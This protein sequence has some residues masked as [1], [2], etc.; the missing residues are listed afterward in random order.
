MGL[1][2]L[3]IN[4]PL[5][6]LMF[7]CALVIL[8]LVSVS[9]MK[10]DRLPNISFPFVGVNVAYPGASPLDVES[11]VTKQIE[12]S[13]A[14]LAG[15]QSITSNSSEGRANVNLQLV[16]GADAQVTAVD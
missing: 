1:T 11:L 6:M 3:A 8:G 14:G 5:A 4:R 2:R 15:V 12:G 7:I 16:E 13:M 10:V 9:L